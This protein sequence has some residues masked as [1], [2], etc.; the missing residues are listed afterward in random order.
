MARR[1]C[2]LVAAALVV[3]LVVQM[4]RSA[5]HRISLESFDP[6]AVARLETDLWRSYYERRHVRLFWG[7]LTLLRTQ[8]Y[9][10]PVMRVTDAYRAAHAAFV[11]KRGRGRA[12]YEQALP[13]LDRYYADIDALAKRPFDS[14]ETARLELEWWIL[15]REGSPKLATALAALQAQIYGIS[16]SRFSEHGRL[17]AEAMVLRDNK[18][19]AITDADWQRIGE[20][21][22]RS[23][24]SLHEVVNAPAA[25]GTR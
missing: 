1:W 17:R 4:E 10:P 16:A 19:A 11:F 21:L 25:A 14:R 2:W 22:D 20:M 24:T 23:W 9:M 15:H 6:H 13:D 8:Y 7:M 3:L 12:D 5:R 18:G